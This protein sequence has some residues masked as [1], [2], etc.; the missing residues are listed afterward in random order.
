MCFLCMPKPFV[1][2]NCKGVAKLVP[3]LELNNQA[4]LFPQV[5]CCNDANNHRTVLCYNDKHV[6]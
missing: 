4:P 5:T 2:T 6:S 1:S 3:S